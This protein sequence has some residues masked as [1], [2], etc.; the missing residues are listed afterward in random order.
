MPTPPFGYPRISHTN[1]RPFSSKHI[2]TGSTTAGSLATSSILKPSGSLNDSFSSFGVSG[3]GGFGN[4][5][6]FAASSFTFATIAS[7]MVALHLPG[8]P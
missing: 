2:A 8:I 4:S 1:S 3:P 7:S 5:A 6:T